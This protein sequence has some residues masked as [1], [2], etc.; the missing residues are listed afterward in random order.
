MQRTDVVVIGA[1]QAGLAISHELATHGIDHAVLERR[2]TAER[3]RSERWASLRLLTPNWFA[4]LPGWRYRGPEPDGFMTAAATADYLRAYARSFE[5]PV[6]EGVEVLA[7]EGSAWRYRV[8]TTAGVHAARAVVVATGACDRP[9]VPAFARRLEAHQL[10]PS[11][12]R[13]PTALPSGGVLV[14]GASASGVQIADELRR[15]GRAVTL[16][17]SRHIR[18]PRTYRGHDLIWLLD[19]AGILDERH[20]AVPDLAHARNQPS[21]Q[22]VG[23][24]D[25]RN[26]DLATLGAAGVR[27]LGRA[28]DGTDRELRFAGDL[29]ATTDAADRKLRR[30]LR[31]IDAAL[32]DLPADAGPAP[33]V[34]DAPPTTL[35]LR[36][37]GIETVIWA[38]GFER[39]Y[40][41]LRL[42][43]L[44]ERGEIAHDGGITALP[45]VYALGLPFLRRR[46]S[47]FID[48]VGDD[49][50][51]LARHLA[52]HLPAGLNPRGVTAMRSPAS[53]LPR[54]VDV[55]VIGARCAGAA[56]AM[57]LA[58]DGAKVLAVD[59]GREGDD[60]LSTHALMRGA[61]VQLQRW[62]VLDQ[63]RAAGTPP[64]RLTTFH[65]GEVAAPV[66]I[67][68]QYGVDALY[69]PK[70]TVLDPLLVQAARRAGAEVAFGWSLQDLLRDQAGRVVGAVLRERS[71][72][73]FEVRARLV[74]GADGVASRTARLV[75]APVVHQGK[76]RSA[77]LY[78]YLAGLRDEGY[79]WHFAP[80]AT[81]GAIPTNGGDHVV[82]V[83]V[84]AARRAEAMAGEPAAC[85]MRLLRAVA[86]ALADEVGD[87]RVPLRSFD[88][89]TGFL[90]Q[91]YGP[92]W[93]LV[94][95]AGYFKDPATAHG[96][97]DALRDAELLARAA[98]VG[99][100]AAFAGYRHLR[101]ALSLPMLRVTDSIASCAW[102]L[103]ELR[104]LHAGLADAMRTELLVMAGLHD[105]AD[106]RALRASA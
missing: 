101:D 20:D 26:I 102:T 3:W 81:A 80:G 4:R 82:F 49:A 10:S 91:P 104:H 79:R 5:A 92:G 55:L 62:G 65:Y 37:E 32:P 51:E 15:S 40:P 50:R 93:A 8:V 94:G 90:R 41:W 86:P 16:A 19:R 74:V 71:G 47:T 78:G 44:D 22:L 28:V 67:E 75:E 54:D 13:D 25:R 85:L 88:G 23:H 35:D 11:T 9:L 45:G 69:A 27:L 36:A 103:D 24:R 106:H 56:T 98:T 52:A 87:V 39:R 1:G 12:Y 70:R 95:D 89:I 96:I 31:R 105:E 58:R 84:A 64:V 60:T 72:R 53:P 66:R 42:P 76:R 46:K 97:T 73:T 34:L 59:R 100:P 18:A 48:G 57:L 30:L 33:L 61:V 14:V 38:T 68:P 21:L 63:V 29:E 83:S 2:R 7:V 99:T 77:L 17:V 6:L 43:V